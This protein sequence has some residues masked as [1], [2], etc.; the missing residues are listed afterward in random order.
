MIRWSWGW[1]YAQRETRPHVTEGG[2]WEERRRGVLAAFARGWSQGLV[3]RVVAN[4]PS[5]G[6]QGS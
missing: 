3:L 4:E 5:W 2:Y 6:R 1:T